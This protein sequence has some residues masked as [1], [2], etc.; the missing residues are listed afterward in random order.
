MCKGSRTVTV[1]R[2]HFTDYPDASL[3]RAH[4]LMQRH[5]K[6]TEICIAGNHDV[7]VQFKDGSRYVLGGFTVGYSGTG[8]D[9]SYAFLRAAGYM[10]TK[11]DV[12]TM[13][14]PVTLVAGKPYVAPQTSTGEGTTVDGAAKRAMECLPKAARVLDL[15][16]VRTG[17][18]ESAEATGDG[19]ESAREAAL[20]RLPDGAEP[21][22]DVVVEPGPQGEILVQASSKNTVAAAALEHM[23]RDAVV[24]TATALNPG[25]DL[26]PKDRDQKYR[27]EFMPAFSLK[28]ALAVV[29]AKIPEG[30]VIDATSCVTPPKPGFLGLGRRPGEYCISW[31]LPWWR[32]SWKAPWSARV[33]YR[34]PAAVRVRYLL[35]GH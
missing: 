31:I 5:S 7:R 17:E 34:R 35:P 29:Q 32:V 22:A 1:E 4:E 15:T 8:P 13:V 33:A 28:E 12:E 9:Y 20:K 6:P 26:V 18:P 14:P 25:S 21:T 30:A 3:E 10:V 23:P 19:P 2:S 27:T 24:T 16:T 11:A